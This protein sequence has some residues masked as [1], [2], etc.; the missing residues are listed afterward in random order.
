M[1][2]NAL[3][4]KR[5]DLLPQ[6]AWGFRTIRPALFLALWLTLSPLAAQPTPLA[7]TAELQ[8][9]LERLNTVGSLLVLGA[10]PDDENTSVI[11]YFA[12]GRHIRAA[13]LSATRGEGGQNRIGPE[14][15]ELLGLIRTEE[16]RAARRIDGGE[17]FFTRAID[18]GYSTNPEEALAK[19][20]RERLL[21]DM[22]RIIRRFRPD[23]LVSRF[24][25]APG[26][27]G[28]GQHT[29]VGH[30]APEAFEAAADPARFPEQIEQG[31]SAWQAKR[32]YWN[33]YSFT[34]QMEQAEA[35]RPDRL[36][37]DVGDYDP[38]LG[39]SYA[40]IAGES[41]S[42]H[43]SQAMGSPQPKGPVLAFFAHVAGTAAKQDLFEDIDTSWKRVAGSA[44]V[45]RL[46]EKARDEY[47]PTHPEAILPTLFEAYAAME[48]LDDPW[49]PVKRAEL[50]KAIELAAGLWIDAAAKRWDATPGSSLGMTLTVIN[51]SQFPLTWSGTEITGVISQHEPGNHEALLPNQVFEKQVSLP[52]PADAEYSEPEWLRAAPQGDSY[53][54]ADPAQIGEAETP[55]VLQATFRLK[56]PAGVEVEIR[57]P[58]VYRWVDPAYGERS[59]DL[60]IVPPVAVGFTRSNMIFPDARRRTV[61]VQLRGN[62]R[63]GSGSASLAVPS[64]WAVTP[65]S[66][67]F[68]MKRRGQ[69]MTLQFEITPPAAD[70]GGVVAAKLQIG[71][72]VVSRDMRKIEYEHIPIQ[73]VY[74]KAKMRAERAD[75]KLLVT[76]I[77]YVMG[78]GD[79]VPQ[80]LEQLGASVT[81]L[82]EADLASGDLSRFETIV[83][84]IRALDTRPD[85]IAAREHL[86]K[87]VHEGGTLVVQ[88]NTLPF[89]RSASS[90]PAVLGP[91]PLTPSR[92]RVTVE[93][94]PVSFP[95]PDHPL[96][97]APNRITSRDFDGWVQERG[98]YFMSEWDSRYEPI[99][100]SND[101][102]EPPQLGGLL[103][104]RY[105]K[106]VYIF[107]GYAWFRQLPAGVPGAYRI[108]ANLVSAGKTP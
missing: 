47:R 74:P 83:T 70:S 16:L 10:H 97:Q 76:R 15:S 68:E 1:R 14:Q 49:V 85:L 103:Y 11:A 82:S 54:I 2:P 69:E 61:A 38:L 57:K 100:Q 41:R 106:G 22:V 30:L 79:L 52:I 75:V 6:S 29:A 40:E 104:T 43:R 59:R 4:P 80:A 3:A 17:Q 98:L 67:P 48:P 9:L 13:Y 92:N 39:K 18:F 27:G 66:I 12:R 19:W 64:G 5:S 42:M 78:A 34:P 101:P 28:H 84:G 21:S 99:L 72:R 24:P 90:P 25:P 107:T 81:L 45:A 105:G 37:L 86:L 51:R 32:L 26:S 58:V 60:Q 44:R 20:G 94:A 63:H 33:T 65:A 87:Y 73:M 7:G 102:G 56:S 35:K 93:E 46:L 50:V 23:V 62:T 95:N 88:Y 71:D 77:G 53:Q 89:R 8:G 108:F 91:Y 31:L 96:L 36:R 55:P